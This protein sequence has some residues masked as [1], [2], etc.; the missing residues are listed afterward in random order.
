MHGKGEVL[1]VDDE[2][3]LAETYGK[4]LADCGFTAT[5]CENP[6]EAAALIDSNVYDVVVADVVMPVISGLVLLERAH[7]RDPD[8]AVVLI[9]GY[10]DDGS[11]IAEA[12]VGRAFKLMRKP[13]GKRQLCD[14]VTLGVEAAKLGRLARR[15]R[16]RFAG[17][18][19]TAA[20]GGDEFGRRE[21]TAQITLTDDGRVLVGEGVR[22]RL[23]RAVWRALGE[24]GRSLIATS[25]KKA[26]IAALAALAGL[27]IAWAQSKLKGKPDSRPRGGE[28]RRKW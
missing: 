3:S 15:R 7:L 17:E 11:A 8:T 10:V 28:E 1:I 25:A 12:V 19:L 24:W 27:G 22:A 18:S 21:D 5:C 20:A 13:F 14:V 26:L 16:A 23:P 4:L 6:G 9:T 2:P